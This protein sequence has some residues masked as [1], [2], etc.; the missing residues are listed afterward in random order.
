[1]KKKKFTNFCWPMSIKCYWFLSSDVLLIQLRKQSR[2]VLA[3][4]QGTSSQNS[5]FHFLLVEKTRS[6]FCHTLITSQYRHIF[7]CCTIMW[8]QCFLTIYIRFPNLCFVFHWRSYVFSPWQR[9]I[10]KEIFEKFSN[11]GA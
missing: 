10:T 7:C 8:Q 3:I 2:L 11:F 1:M 6:L 9:W 5:S 4:Q